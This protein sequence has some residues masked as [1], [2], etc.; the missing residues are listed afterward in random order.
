MSLR[1][2]KAKDPDAFIEGAGKPKEE[3]TPSDQQGGESQAQSQKEQKPQKPAEPKRKKSQPKPGEKPWE[4]PHVR[5]DVQKPMALRLP[6]PL[7]LKL[8]WIAEQTPYS[9]HSF[10]LEAVEK[11]VE[12][13]LKELEG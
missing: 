8:K 11:A 3:Q 6:E 7:A 2:P 1:R 4:Q 12:K 9:Q 5:S 13:K 10:A